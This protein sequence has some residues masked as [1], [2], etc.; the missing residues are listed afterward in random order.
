MDSSKRF[1]DRVSR[2]DP[3]TP[4]WRFTVRMFRSARPWI[5]LG[6]LVGSLLVA[7][8]ASAATYPFR[9]PRLPMAARVDDLLS[10]L[11]LD[12]KV[13]LLHQYQPA[14]P[15]LGIGVFKAGTEALH[16][17]AWSNDYNDNGNVVTAQATVFPQAIGLAST[18]DPAL[19]RRVGSTVGDEARG[20]N[21]QNPTVWG[22]NLWAPVVNLLRD[23]RWG[24]NEEGYSEDPY[25]T[26]AVSTAYGKGMEG[27][28]P[29][30]LKAAPTLKH[31]L[32]YNNEVNR[33]TSS[34]NVPPRV[35]N[36]YDRMAFEPAIAANAATGVMPSYNLVNGRPNTVNPDLDGVVR[37]WTDKPL[38]NPSDAGAPANLTGAEQYYATQAE[39]DAAAIKA[40]VNSFTQDN[41]DPTGTVTAIKAA[42]SQG[43]LSV[44][45]IDARVR[46][47]LSIRFRLGEFDP[48]GGPYGGLT[49]VNTTAAQQLARQTADEAAVLL[50]NDRSALPLSPARKH[51]AVVG[52]L[53][54]TNYTDWYSGKPPYTVTPLQGVRERLGAGA[55]VRSTEGVDRIALKDVDTGRYVTA[56]GPL[57]EG[58]TT[59]DGTAQFDVFDW[60]QGRLTLR[61]V[62]NDKY[63]GYNFTNFV[64]DQD[65][66][67]G[68]FVQQQFKLEAQPDGTF[69][70]RYAGY[71]ADS[72]WSVPFHTPYLTR[73]ADG[74]LNLGAA[75]AAAATHFT[76]DTLVSGTD[77]A[78]AAAKGADA[79]V[80]VVG[81]MPFING[82]ED[83]DRTTMDLAEGQEALVRAVRAANPN[84]VVVLENSYP[85]T[86][87]WEQAHVPAILWTTHAGQETGHA[88]AD[89][90]F[91]DVNPAGRLTQTWYRSTADLPDIMDYDIIKSGRTYQYFQGDP[92]YP[93]GHGLSYTSFAY[94]DLRVS[95]RYQVSVE[96]TNTGRRPGDEVVQLYTHQR[97][98]RVPQPIKQLRGFQRIHLAPGQHQR[99]TF[100]L[101]AG[102][103]RFW[104]V[105]RSRY[106]TESA[107]HDVMV[108]AS[109]G[110][111][112][113]T[114]RLHVDGETIPPRDLSKLTRAENFDDYQGV[115][116]VDESKA[117][118]TAV[119][120][121][122]GA[123]VQYAGADLR[124]GPAAITA[125][126][127]DPG[128]AT[129]IQVRLDDPVHGRLIGTLQV[130][131]TGDRYTYTTV[132]AP[133]QR[134][135]GRHAVYLV[136]GGQARLATFALR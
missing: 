12:E 38:F 56:S 41:T 54:Q 27:N 85:D 135:G 70:I 55:D 120:S 29:R 95:G 74:T 126:V 82:R 9:D 77:A 116:L 108:G 76:K 67:N 14:I 117:R 24:R 6:A 30:Y 33:A 71:E 83:H 98:S 48:G 44:H 52:P 118:G 79:A 104:D 90:L 31:Y 46:E 1:D 35:L 115:T 78:V 107:T 60:G 5:A 61:N 72:D 113:L 62:A 91:G 131:P 103:F 86:I 97:Q 47:N 43:L 99:V 28:D 128:A 45:D 101:T 10:R 3:P 100:E 134:A 69:V 16:G 4:R 125:S 23:P 11:T 53:S 59:A 58:A 17:V 18:W 20:L 121:A 80:V 8:P 37:S 26:G 110:D 25:L 63:L 109:A 106:V 124:S 13:S 36:E 68:W 64:A 2:S 94:S 40:G 102:D 92:L 130:P 89:I 111:I 15:R 96:V 112:R 136:F 66:P 22:L 129:T 114:G 84:T 57:A 51:V 49:A 65:Q 39:A 133:L 132:T 34:S 50:K 42:L 21:K 105:T 123:W 88:V 81:S 75:T 73:Q 127:A 32:A 7:V 93:I 87:N 122:S 119:G 19:I